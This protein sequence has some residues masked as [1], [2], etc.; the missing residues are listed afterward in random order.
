VARISPPASQDARDQ[1]F[2]M[3]CVANACPQ[4]S[5][6]DGTVRIRTWAGLGWSNDYPVS[7]PL[8]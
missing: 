5:S 1:V 7:P 4:N 2:S 3:I 8:P 6:E